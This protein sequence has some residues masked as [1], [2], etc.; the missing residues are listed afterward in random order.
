MARVQ[1]FKT[2]QPPNNIKTNTTDCLYIHTH[3]YIHAYIHT[4]THT[5][6]H[7]YIQTYIHTYIHTYKHTYIHT[8]IQTYIQAYIHG[9]N[10][11]SLTI[12]QSS[13]YNLQSLC[14]H[15]LHCINAT[16]CHGMNSSTT[17][18]NNTGTSCEEDY[19]E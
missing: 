2:T 18:L 15:L 13:A 4:Y 19:T 5:N 12:F 1:I 3:T 14:H 17:I 7:T 9:L 8:N 16:K 10:A 6:I 11:I